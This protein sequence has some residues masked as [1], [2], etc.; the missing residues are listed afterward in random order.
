[1]TDSLIAAVTIV[2]YMEWSYGTHKNYVA[3]YVGFIYYY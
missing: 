3:Q 1:M 2:T